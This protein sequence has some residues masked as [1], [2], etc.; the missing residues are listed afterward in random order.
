MELLFYARVPVLF[1]LVH[2]QEDP[3]ACA[4]SGDVILGPAND[5]TLFR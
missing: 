5:V 3:H 2:M 1:C 4:D